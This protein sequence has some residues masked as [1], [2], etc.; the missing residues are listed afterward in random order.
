MENTRKI[1]SRDKVQKDNN[2]KKII[3]LQTKD[4]IKESTIS[5]KEIEN[6]KMKIKKEANNFYLQNQKNINQINLP[7]QTNNIIISPKIEKNTNNNNLNENNKNII[8]NDFNNN[9][10]LKLDDDIKN[11]PINIINVNHVNVLYQNNKNPNYILKEYANINNEK[12]NQIED[13]R[14]SMEF[15]IN[16]KVQNI[17]NNTNK[18]IPL[19]KEQIDLIICDI[20]I[21][22]NCLSNYKG[23]IFLQNALLFIDDKE[24]TILLNTISSYLARIMCMEYG[25]YFIQKLIKKLNAQQR[26]RIYQII[27]NEFLFI[28]INKSG[29]H[30]IQTLIDS[31]QTPLEKMVLDKLLNKDLLLLFNNENGYHIIMKIILDI[32]ENQRNNINLFIVA[33][34]EKIIINPYG[35]YCISKFIINNSNLNLRSLLINNIHNNIKNLIFNKNSCSVL[36]LAIKKFGIN[37]LEF[38]I[39]EIENNLSFLSLHP[40]SN[41]LVIKILNYLKNTKYYKLNSIIWNIYRND[42][43]IRTLISHKNGNKILKKIMEYSNNTQKKYIKAKLNIIEK[44][45]NNKI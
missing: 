16:K 14:N 38:I 11:Y 41:I 26:I 9:N 19:K 7:D 13:L 22:L 10:A 33:N 20:S 15:N 35:A 37:S 1:L 27:E 36:M 29:T 43:L 40:V 21:I 4:N 5:N 34:L 2:S 17:N 24:L 18:I 23:S 30:V 44:N 28:S 3:S 42:N 31:I 25:N 39:N 8:I 45:N 12:N 6:D 32:P